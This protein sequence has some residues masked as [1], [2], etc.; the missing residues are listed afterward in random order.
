[1]ILKDFCK[2]NNYNCATCNRSFN[3]YYSENYFNL[4][5]GIHGCVEENHICID[6]ESKIF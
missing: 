4:Y 2:E 5:C 1:M 3:N 6:Y